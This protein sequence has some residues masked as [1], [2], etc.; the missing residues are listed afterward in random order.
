MSY[1]YEDYIDPRSLSKDLEVR[2][3]SIT[4]PAGRSKGLTSQTQVKKLKQE[5]INPT[6]ETVEKFKRDI[7]ITPKLEENEYS[8]D[9][10]QLQKGVA[11]ILS[12]NVSL[13][14]AQRNLEAKLNKA[15]K[16][17]KS[18]KVIQAIKQ[19][20]ANITLELDGEVLERIELCLVKAFLLNN[21]QIQS[22]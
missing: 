11:K 22:Y 16:E 2:A 8:R 4:S 20:T 5:F 10:G 18:E 7:G 3:E 14:A 17:G 15:I 19:Q 1:F 12:M 21:F 6:P 9:I 13:S